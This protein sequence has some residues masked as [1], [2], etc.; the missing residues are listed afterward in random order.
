MDGMEVERKREKAEYDGKI[1]ALTA[2]KE[3]EIPK[4]S[5]GATY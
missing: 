2:Q 4:K 3:S 1:D 5:I